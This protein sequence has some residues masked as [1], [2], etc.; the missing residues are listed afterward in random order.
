M[1]RIKCLESL[2]ALSFLSV[3]LATI[4][5]ILPI[6]SAFAQDPPESEAAITLEEI[7]VTGSLIRRDDFSSATPTT[8]FDSDYLDNLG[9][10]NLG[11]A[12]AQIP[13]NINTNNPA[14][15]AGAF[16]PGS[17]F[18]NG[19]SIANL[20]GLNPFFGSRTLTL[21]DSRRHVPTNQGDG[22]DLN[23]IPTVLIDRMEVVTGGASASY[24]S[25]AIG[26]VT[27]ILLDR[28][29]DGFRAEI[30]FAD[31][32]R[33]DAGDSHVGLAWGTPIGEGGR[34]GNFVIGV[35]VEDLADMPNCGLS[36]RDW[37]AQNVGTIQNPNWPDD[38]NPEHIIRGGL[39]GAWSSPNGLFWL[40]GLGGRTPNAGGVVPGVQFTADGRGLIDYDPGMWGDDFFD[41]TAIG[42]DG[43]GLYEDS[44]LRSNVER[45]VVYASYTTQF[46]DDLGFFAE[47]SLGE[48]STWSPSTGQASNY[49]CMRSDYAFIDPRYTGGDTTIRDF[50]LEQEANAGFF[51]GPFPCWGGGVPIRKSWFGQ[52]DYGNATTTDLTRFAFGLDGRFGDSSWTWNAYAQFGESDRTQSV[53]DVAFENRWGYGF[54]AVI[55]PATGQPAC[56]VD[57]DPGI[58]TP[59]LVAPFYS[60]P[61][62]LLANPVLSE[63]CV[64]INILG[65]NLTDEMRE[66]GW[67]FLRED[68]VVK[69]DMYEFLSSGDIGAGFGAGPIRAAAG[70][71]F[72]KESI[73]N[74]GAEELGPLRTDFAIQ[75]GESFGGDVDVLEYFGELD[76]PLH[77]NVDIQVAARQS[78]YEHTAGRGT[79]VP[80]EQYSHDITTWKLGGA[81][82]VVPSFRVRFSTSKD[83]RAPNFR[84]LYYGQIFVPG[85]FFGFVD[86]PWTQNTMDPVQSALYGG[87][88]VKPEEADTNTIGF[89]IQP[90][91]TNLRLGLD[92]YE[93]D[94]QDAIT[95]ANL[96]LNLD[97]CYDGNQEACDRMS[98][99]TTPWRD[100]AMDHLGMGVPGGMDS[101]PCPA[102]CF[103]DIETQYHTAFNFRRYETSGL[104]FTF[105]WITPLPV[106]TFN[107]RVIGSRTFHQIIQPNATNPNLFE[108][109]AGVT[110]NAVSFLSDWAAAPDLTANVI[111]TW[112]RDRFSITGQ[113]RWISEGVNVPTR[114]GPDD[115]DYS[116]SLDESQN[117]N[118]VPDYAVYTLSGT[119]DFD[120][121]ADRSMQLYAVV[122]NLFDKDPPFLGSGGAFFGTGTTLGT[123]PVF[124]DTL[125]R[126]YRIG[127]RMEF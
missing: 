2:R 121:G 37:C 94:L 120:T 68:T 58:T 95:P 40:P 93:I 48:V 73:S 119:Y 85:S 106:G 81:W 52:I 116:P 6:G 103:V 13:A 16:G 112:V 108:D 98:G 82:D 97:L 30:D 43:M 86:N 15:G 34:G 115:P 75:Y 23:F 109:L 8:V 92:Y 38:G 45:N 67:G 87:P 63:G 114:I 69:Q 74:V 64:P 5:A 70:I 14:V 9:I 24:G 36:G 110:G 77:E 20:R 44:R 125:G 19:S 91:G 111:A 53:N 42:G 124:F 31:T 71:S 62:R 35:E 27:N 126:R 96:G 83:I 28:T 12:I 107:L 117:E 89:V 76:I 57:V 29:L 90:A 60:V 25:G 105:D 51:A 47:A 78:S 11:D 59:H 33:G 50:I 49:W 123:Q 101:V 88:D 113:M 4:V 72:R 10:V 84:E 18:F 118:T 122:N 66:Y 17:N 104:D 7:T 100:P 80:G 1:N 61:G 32:T 99:T 39:R 102:T 127:L 56:R 3:A 22:V 54:D 55:D 46:A 21:V 65:Q 41:G 26:G 79:P